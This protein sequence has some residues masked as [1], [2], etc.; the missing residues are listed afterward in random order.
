VLFNSY[1]FLFGFLPVTLVGF[2]ALGL[3]SRG[4]AFSWLVA[5]SL[6]FYAWWRPV[7]VLIIAPSLAVNYLIARALARPEESRR[8]E[9]ARKALLTA[10]IL[11]NLAFLGYFKYTNF[12]ADVVNDV[13]GTHLLWSQVI[14]PLGISFITFQKIAFLVDVHAGRVTTFTFGQYL[15]F[16]L[17]FP[18]LIAGPIVHFREMMP[19]FERVTARFNPTDVAVG[20]TL[21]GIG[22]F[23]KVVLA[24]GMAQYVSPIYQAAASGTPITFVAGWMAAVGFTLQIY[25]DF[26]GYSDMALGLG[27]CFGVRLPANFDSPLK[28][29]SII[30]FW[31]RW[32]ITLTRFLSGYLYNPLVLWLSRRRLVAGKP[33]VAGRRTP[34]GAFLQLL[35]VPTIV[36]MGVSGLWHGAG[37][38]FVLWGLI[39]GVYLCA[40]HAWRFYGPKPRLGQSR[41]PW[42]A[43]VPGFLLTFAAVVVAMV[44]FRSPTLETAVAVLSGMVAAN[45][46][47]APQGL[48]SVAWL[49]GL[50]GIALLLPNS[51][52]IMG[53]YEPALGIDDRRRSDASLWR[54][55]RWSPSFSWAVAIGIVLVIVV[56]RLGPE[57]EFLYWQF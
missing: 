52:E 13:A 28:A 49:T 25:F 10:G 17:F 38:T 12:L 48:M 1:E 37:Y 19:Q 29:A 16:V 11:F 46:T 50:L 36:T 55:F 54:W 45:G 4:L 9:P 14:L 22:L 23:K 15:L 51:L 41:M 31:A 20:L 6:G 47:G 2:F 27:R 26:S 53:R 21:L 32:H 39:H 8:S 5:A 56:M 35:I 30:D 42:L 7:N 57:S 34:L 18:Q 44:L 3:A 43:P 40:N 33:G 24:D